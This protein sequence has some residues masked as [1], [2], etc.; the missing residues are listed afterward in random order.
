MDSSKGLIGKSS[1]DN[2][3]LPQYEGAPADMGGYDE[4]LDMGAEGG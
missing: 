4:P 2:S 3:N 1:K